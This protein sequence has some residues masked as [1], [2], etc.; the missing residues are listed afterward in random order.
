MK[1]IKVQIKELLENQEHILEAVKNLNERLERIEQ[2]TNDEKL[3]DI[4]NILESQT[5]IDEI[6]VKNSDD[7]ILMKKTKKNSETALILLES[8]IDMLDEEITKFITLKV[9]EKDESVTE[10]DNTLKKICKYYNRG[11]CKSLDN[12]PFYHPTELC[13]KF[14]G[15]HICVNFNCRKRHPKKC[16]YWK[17]GDCWRGDGCLYSHNL[18]Q[19]DE[20]FKTIDD[21]DHICDRCSKATKKRYYCEICRLDFCEHCTNEAAH[22]MNIYL[23]K[24]AVCCEQI[25]KP[26]KNIKEMQFDAIVVNDNNTENMNELLIENLCMCGQM[27]NENAFQCNY[28]RKYFCKNCPTG[29]LNFDDQEECLVCLGLDDKIYTSTPEKDQLKHKLDVSETM[30]M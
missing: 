9:K 8:K 17:L 5:M 1:N 22:E 2:K 23:N 3:D 11:F 30:Q 26:L 16:R 6:I 18:G 29:P 25:H 4:K 13:E 21:R 7:I 24:E 28:C 10:D 27:M 15:D 12:C 20:H 19:N 14:K